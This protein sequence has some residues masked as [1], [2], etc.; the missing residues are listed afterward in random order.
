MIFEL[1]YKLHLKFMQVSFRHHKLFYFHLSFWIWKV[2]K[3]RGKKYKKWNILRTKKAFTMKEKTFFIV[4]EGLSIGEKK[5]KIKKMA[6]TSLT[7]FFEYCYFKKNQENFWN[8]LLQKLLVNNKHYVS[9]MLIAKE[10]L[11]TFTLI[12]KLPD[13][14][15]F[16][17]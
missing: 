7:F 11:V 16:I 6:D 3:G 13:T 2:W 4:F 12:L 17:G 1:L 8:F 14:F 5:T 15:S 10:C 9:T